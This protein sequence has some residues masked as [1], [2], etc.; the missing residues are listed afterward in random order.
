LTC[1]KG[2]NWL[3]PLNLQWL[4]CALYDRNGMTNVRT[5]SLVFAR[6]FISAWIGAGILFVIVAV[7]EVG[8]PDFTSLTKSQL[9]L[10][11]FP[12]Y[13]AF[14]MA[15]WLMSVIFLLLA[16]GHA[17]VRKWQWWSTLM[18]LACAGVVMLCDYNL[19]YLPLAVMTRQFD[20]PRTERFDFY[21]QASLWLNTLQLSLTLL[22]AIVISISHQKQSGQTQ[23]AKSRTNRNGNQ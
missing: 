18:L 5:I 10:L 2:Q 3:S 1:R 19:I 8:S 9:A 20:Q 22:A 17:S 15:T 11:R 13:Y 14:G 12:A 23:T 7:L 21:H 4:S 16:Y 6:I